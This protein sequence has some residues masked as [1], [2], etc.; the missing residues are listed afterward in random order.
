MSRKGVGSTAERDLLAKFWN[1]GW[2]SMR[3]A[4][5]GS[6]RWPSPDLVVGTPLR[7][8]AI[9]CKKTKSNKKYIKKDEI[10][11]LMVFASSFGAEA[12]IAIKFYHEPWFFVALS[13]LEE[14]EG[15]YLISVD[16]VKSAGILF[17]EL[18]ETK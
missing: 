13:D 11:Q 7:K 15:S 12:W 1:I 8:L 10:N 16:A 9:E 18:V 17:E 2:A 14:K 3:S 4:G 6:S 5:S